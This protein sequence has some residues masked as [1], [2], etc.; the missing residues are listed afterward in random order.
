M[1]RRD[2]I[3]FFSSAFLGEQNNSGLTDMRVGWYYQPLLAY[4]EISVLVF[5]LFRYWLQWQH[6][7][8]KERSAENDVWADL[9]L[10]HLDWS[11]LI[12]FYCLTVNYPTSITYWIDNHIW[13]IICRPLYTK[14]FFSLISVKRPKTAYRSGS[15]VNHTF[16]LYTLFAFTWHCHLASISIIFPEYWFKIYIL[17]SISN[18]HLSTFNSVTVKVHIHRFKWRGLIDE[19]LHSLSVPLPKQEQLASMDINLKGQLH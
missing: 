14:I 19:Q 3:E 7:C 6:L 5:V 16:Y 13:G 8:F 18:I 10:L 11:L 12:I 15:N 4:P 9:W 1:S 17:L 2:Q